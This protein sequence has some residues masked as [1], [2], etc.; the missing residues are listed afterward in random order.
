MLCKRI[1]KESLSILKFGNLIE[2]IL[3]Y[4]K[5][6][7]EFSKVIKKNK[8]VIDNNKDKLK[9]KGLYGYNT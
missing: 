6:R 1:L 7:K 3:Y 5:E 2:T 4:F 9:I 8:E